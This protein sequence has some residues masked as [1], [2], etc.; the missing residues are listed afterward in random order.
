MGVTR[1][2]Q[3]NQDMSGWEGEQKQN[4]IYQDQSGALSLVQIIEILCPH[5]LNLTMLAPSSMP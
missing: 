2:D 5:W 4:K 1:R 3:D